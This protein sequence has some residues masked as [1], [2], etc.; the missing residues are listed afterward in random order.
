MNCVVRLLV[1][2]VVNRVMNRWMIVKLSRCCRCEEVVGME[3]RCGVVGMGWI[4]GVGWCVMVFV[5]IG[6][7]VVGM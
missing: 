3:M 2:V 7:I 1:S 6:C 5:L 4:V